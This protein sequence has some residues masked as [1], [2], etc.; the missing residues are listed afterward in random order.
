MPP[1]K[2]PPDSPEEWLRRALSNLKL[3]SCNQ[4]DICLENLCFEAQQAVEKSL[5]ALH[6]KYN[7]EF[8][9][10]HDLE[11][12]ITSLEKNGLQIPNEVKEA[13]ILTNYAVAIRYPGAEVVTEKDYY[14]A[15]RLAQA[16]YEWVK[17]L[18]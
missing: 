3:A 12:L 6:L 18:V 1:D 4:E 7:I 2:A 13:V 5:K 8:R 14:Q 16:V 9:Y 11:E 10:V 17:D 15:L